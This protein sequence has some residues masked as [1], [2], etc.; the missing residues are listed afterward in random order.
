MIF[1]VLL[2][3]RGLIIQI[4]RPVD[5]FVDDQ[6]YCVDDLRQGVFQNGFIF[7]GEA[8]EY[9]VLEIIVGMRLFA[10]A[11][12]DARKRVRSAEIDDVLDAVL[13]AVGA[14]SADADVADVEVDIVAEDDHLL[15]RELV[16]PHRLGDRLTAEVHEGGRLHQEASVT[17]EGRFAYR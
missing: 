12:L 16:E 13:T 1:A 15:G 11:D 5:I 7:I 10:D 14:F 17:G 9:P 4:H 8:G 2:Q 6:S 3:R